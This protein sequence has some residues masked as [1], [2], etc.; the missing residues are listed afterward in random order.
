[1]PIDADVRSFLAATPVFKD[2]PAADLDEIAGACVV[3][4]RAAGEL[5]LRQGAP[6]DGVHFLRSGQL[7]VRVQRGAER[8]TVNFIQ[9]PSV[10][11]E[12][13]YITG[14]SCVADVEVTVDAEI[15]FLPGDAAPVGSPLRMKILQGLTTMV[16][17]RLR[18]TVLRGAK[19]PEHPTI[20]LHNL[21]HWE[22]PR[23]FAMQLARTLA[24]QQRRPTLLVNIHH[25]A[26]NSMVDKGAITVCEWQ[27]AASQSSLREDMARKITEWKVRFENLILNPIGPDAGAVAES[28]NELV[29]FHGDLAGPGDPLR[30][31]G[32]DRFLVQSNALPTIPV[33][34]GSRQLIADA[35][36]AEAAE[37]AGQPLPA[38]FC[39]T[40]DSMARRV[41]GT[42]VGLALGGGAAW[43]WAHIGVLRVLEEAG[44]PVDMISGCSMGSVIG[45]FRAAGFTVDQMHDLALYWRSHTRRFIE[46][47]FWKMSLLNEKTVRSVFRG[48]F[49][50][51]TVNQTAIPY[52]ANA[53]DIQTG[54][55]YT[56][57]QGTLVD[58]VRA[59]IALP[60][61]MPPLE[62]GRH[63]LVDAG[64]MDPVPVSLARTMGAHFVIAI[65]AMAELEGQPIHRSYPLNG[66]DIMTRCMFVM[67][68]EI[69]QARAEQQAN[70][71]FTPKLGKITMLQFGLSEEIMKCG[72]DAAHQNLEHIM[73]SYR[74]WRQ[75]HRVLAGK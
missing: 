22:A 1:M 53:V 16:A 50:E 44:L 68:H 63:L 11:G 55:E 42:Q 47:R 14:R 57:N 6:G 4:K 48:Y 41:A 66:F 74:Q 56:F 40:A 5:I 29:N 9:P 59:S 2:L 34:N 52:W 8:E 33:L 39:R 31:E 71:V 17:E 65:N 13:S 24:E 49:G 32:E 10:V 61:L 67:G 73:N 3:N 20:L 72:H 54:R 46:W 69:G 19:A 51:R 64:I 35:A 28:L 58:C 36:A 38:S 62:R 43:G 7:A 27:A 23:S 45:A 70:V 37:S 18:E 26:D 30:A 75:Q 12:L 21:P 25:Q 15:V 60:G